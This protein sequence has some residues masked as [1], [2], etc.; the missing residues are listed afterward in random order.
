MFE[1]EIRIRQAEMIREADTHRLARQVRQARRS[2]R[3]SAK[4][5]GED[6][7]ST[8]ADSA[9]FARAA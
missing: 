1:N 8:A 4:N 5:A 7:V 2:A 6:R 9:R 3:R